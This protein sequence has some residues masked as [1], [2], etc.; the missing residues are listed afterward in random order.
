MVKIAYHSIRRT[1][2]RHGWCCSSIQS[3]DRR[4]GKGWLGSLEYWL[5]SQFPGLHTPIWFEYELFPPTLV[6]HSWSLRRC[7][8]LE[9][10][11]LG[12]QSQVFHH[13]NVK[14]YQ[15]RHWSSPEILHRSI[16]ELH[17]IRE[18]ANSWFYQP[19]TSNQAP[20]LAEVFESHLAGRRLPP[21]SLTCIVILVI[22]QED[23]DLVGPPGLEISRF[24]TS[25][26][27]LPKNSLGCRK[28]RWKFDYF[29]W[30][31]MIK[32]EVKEVIKSQFW[33]LCDMNTD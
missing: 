10:L 25:G 15:Y 18:V 31:N 5:C 8:K 23:E 21:W 26:S 17:L 6:L 14:S 32:M 22:A 33:W 11:G 19:D 7:W 27:E 29:S 1:G 9:C 12:L 28:P 3:L 20:S 2:Q 24:A 30:T 4:K 13:S 16:Q